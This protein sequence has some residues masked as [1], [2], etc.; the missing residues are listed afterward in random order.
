[1]DF[2]IVLKIFGCVAAIAATARVVF[3]FSS[4]GKARLRDEYRFAK[5]FLTDID[6][7]KPL[8]PLV[9][10]RGYLAIAGNSRIS[11]DEIAYLIE[12]ENPSS[13]L[14]DYVLARHYVEF[15]AQKNQIEFKKKY[16]KNFARIWRKVAWITVY[17][18]ASVIALSPFLVIGIFKLHPRY[19]AFLLVTLPTFGFF[20]VDA[21]RLVVKLRRAEKL[22]NSQLKHTSVISLGK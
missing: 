20:A 3:E 18:I 19:Y 10:E 13:R 12:L 7:K 9:V 17:F 6:N 8:H 21:L 22:V 4:G 2:E 14:K 1:M 5:E 11:S 15:R 16:A